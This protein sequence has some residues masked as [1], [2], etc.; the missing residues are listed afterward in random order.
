MATIRH[1]QLGV[2]VWGAIQGIDIV[3][4]PMIFDCHGHYMFFINNDETGTTTS[5]WMLAPSRSIVGQIAKDI[6]A[7]R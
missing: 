4:K 2:M 7:K 3:A 5:G 1:T 6:C